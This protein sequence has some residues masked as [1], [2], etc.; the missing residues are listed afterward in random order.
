MIAELITE[1]WL[2]SV[3]FMWHQHTR[4]PDKHWILWLGSNLRE[5]QRSLVSTEDIGIE[6]TPC[7]R[8]NGETPEWFCWLRSDAAGKYHR[9]IHL[10]HIVTQADLIQ[11]V[12]AIT[13]RE[14]LPENHFHGIAESPERAAARRA[15]YDRLDRRLRDSNPWYDVERDP[16]EHG[17]IIEDT[18]S[19]RVG[20]SKE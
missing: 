10:R 12:K 4:Q 5:E 9:F 14:W 8:L 15:D 7:M 2:K 6:V 18:Y 16:S 11:L 13:G 1:D 17:A 19:V 3:G 20:R